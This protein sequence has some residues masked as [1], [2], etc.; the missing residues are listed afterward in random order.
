MPFSKNFAVLLV[1]IGD[2][3]FIL[4]F[5]HSIL[6]LDPG[7]FEEDVPCSFCDNILNLQLRIWTYRMGA[8]CGF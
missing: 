1:H 5:K 4:D 6:E 8:N 7:Y 3:Q 2:Q